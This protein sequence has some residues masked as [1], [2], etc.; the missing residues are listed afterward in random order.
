[1]PD[2]VELRCLPPGAIGVAA[3]TGDAFKV[4]EVRVEREPLV[5]GAHVK[6]GDTIFV[7]KEASVQVDRLSLAGGRHGRFFMFV[8]DNAVHSSPSRRDVPRLIQDLSNLE[9]QMVEHF[10]QDPL[11]SQRGPETPLERAASAE[12]AI[13]NL[14][15]DAAV[16]LPE[17]TARDSGAVCLFFHGEAACVAVSSMSVKK[18]RALMAALGRPVNPHVVDEDTLRTLFDGVYGKADVGPAS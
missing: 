1:M 16:C 4:D 14:M 8:D 15:M 11:A 3:V 12:F 2:F 10:G 9:A 6:V 5:R 13:Q 17:K 7:D 18:I